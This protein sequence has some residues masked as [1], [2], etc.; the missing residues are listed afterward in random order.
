MLRHASCDNASVLL[1]MLRV[2]NVIGKETR[3]PAREALLRHVSL[4][5][6]E[7]QTGHLIEEDRQ[8]IKRSSE[9]ILLQWRG[10]PRLESTATPYASVVADNTAVS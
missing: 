1:H 3:S 2:I 5:Q 7:S 4:V 6:V 8:L 10:F 9:A